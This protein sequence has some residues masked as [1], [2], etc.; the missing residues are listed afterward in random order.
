MWPRPL[1]LLSGHH[2]LPPN[3]R[4]MP[5]LQIRWREGA[6]ASCR[7]ATTFPPTAGSG[8]RE[9]TAPGRHCL[10]FCR[11]ILRRGG[12]FPLLPSP[13]APPTA[14]AIAAASLPLLRAPARV[15]PPPTPPVGER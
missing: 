9:G 2:L 12:R 5:S 14:T 4:F 8:G 10:P 15:R 11:R 6:A 13:L 3:R 1:L 7:A